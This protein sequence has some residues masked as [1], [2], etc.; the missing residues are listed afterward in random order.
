MRA[1]HSPNMM[2]VTQVVE[3]DI[4]VIAPEAA[5]RFDCVPLRDV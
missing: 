2:S 1:A 3:A 5:G 4:C